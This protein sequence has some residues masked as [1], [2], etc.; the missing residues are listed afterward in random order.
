LVGF[1]TEL[2]EG[3]GGGGS[4]EQAGRGR[5]DLVRALRSKVVSL[6]AP[7]APVPVE[8]SLLA[9]FIPPRAEAVSCPAPA[10]VP[11]GRVVFKGGTGT[12]MASPEEELLG[13][14]T[15]VEDWSR[16]PP[17]PPAPVPRG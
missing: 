1:L 17:A 7:T 2:P 13:R 10:P 4:Q 3:G 14:E 9:V 5:G 8:R 15:E 11:G 16:D 6:V 12:G